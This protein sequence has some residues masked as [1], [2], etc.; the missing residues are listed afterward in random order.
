[1]YT[2][3]QALSRR[4]IF[5]AGRPLDHALIDSDVDLNRDL[6]LKFFYYQ[7]EISL[8]HA[9]RLGKNIVLR[10]HT[11]SAYPF[12]G[13]KDKLP[14]LEYLSAITK[15]TPFSVD[16]HLWRPILTVRH[17]VDCFISSIKKGW[18]V[19][20]APD[21]LFD[22]YCKEIL[23]MQV[24]Y[25]E[26]WN[27][28]IL[29]YEDLCSHADNFFEQL[30]IGMQCPVLKFPDHTEVSSVSVTGQSGRPQSQQI[31]YRPRQLDLIDQNLVEQLKNSKNYQALCTRNGYNSCIY[32]DPL[33][34]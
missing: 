18:A 33:M 1:M 32:A 4:H 3:E 9:S 6:R 16:Y 15:A 22:T 20:Y 34:Q 2:R 27:A 10:E 30:V 7:L 26:N 17:P 5:K 21:L 25:K 23:A 14:L 29:R 12:C 28:L 19:N 24:Y 11:H 31:G 8:L 13:K